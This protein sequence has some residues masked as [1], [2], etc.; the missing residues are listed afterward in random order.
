[1]RWLVTAAAP[2]A[3]PCSPVP[4]EQGRGG[5]SEPLTPN[6]ETAR[7][8]KLTGNLRTVIDGHSPEN[9]ELVPRALRL[10]AAVIAAAGA[11]LLTVMAVHYHGADSYSAADRWVLGVLPRGPGV[12][13]S[14]FSY[15]IDLVPPVSVLVVGVLTVVHLVMGRLWQAVFVVAAPGLTLLITELG[16]RLVNRTIDGVPALPSGHA[17]GVTSV[18]VVVAVLLVDRVRAHVLATA[19]LLLLAVT[20]MAVGIG[21]VM[22]VTGYHYPTDTVA[23]FFTGLACTLGVALGVDRLARRRGGARPLALS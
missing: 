13:Y 5:H 7:R 17:A 18:S 2:R 1:M 22:S 15:L 3:R 12:P 10:P 6:D 4:S 23:G 8:E 9:T 14:T 16:K 11:L 20:G 19:G 21:V